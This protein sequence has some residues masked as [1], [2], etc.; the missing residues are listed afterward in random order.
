MQPVTLDWIPGGWIGDNFREEIRQTMFLPHE[1][2][3]IMVIT[4]FQNGP[5]IHLVRVGK[6]QKGRFRP[7]L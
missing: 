3:T 1:P 4:H 2:T 5:N 7:L 6:T